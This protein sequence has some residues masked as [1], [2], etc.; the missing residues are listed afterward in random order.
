MERSFDLLRRIFND[1]DN[2]NPLMCFIEGLAERDRPKAK[3]IIK[4]AERHEDQVDNAIVEGMVAGMVAGFDVGFVYG[5]MFD[6]TDPEG[7]K[8]METLRRKLIHD[9]TLMF[10]PREKKAEAT[11]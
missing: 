6:L 5:Q 7:K 2:E 10:V 3:W 8:Y 1:N 4:G 9:G 11:K